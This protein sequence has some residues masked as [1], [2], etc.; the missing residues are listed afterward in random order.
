MINKEWWCEWFH[1]GGRLE[2]DEQ[3]RINWRCECGRWSDTPIPLGEELAVIEHDIKTFE[4][5]SLF[6]GMDG[7]GSMFTSGISLSFKAGVPTLLEVNG[8]QYKVLSPKHDDLDFLRKVYNPES[9]TT[10]RE[11]LNEATERL[12]V[13]QP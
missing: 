10:T 8:T 5:A 12:K 13:Y 9:N 4:P 3:G 2:R 7:T 11:L 1:N 6:V